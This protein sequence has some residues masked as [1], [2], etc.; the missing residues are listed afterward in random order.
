[1]RFAI[2]W[3]NKRVAKIFIIRHGCANLI[4]LLKM[5]FCEMLN[6]VFYGLEIV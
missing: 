2:V 4:G 3:R 5:M 6:V 1:M